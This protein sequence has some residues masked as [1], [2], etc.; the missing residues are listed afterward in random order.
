M[1]VWVTGGSRGL[2]LSAIKIFAQAGHIVYAGLLKTDNPNMLKELQSEYHAYIHI[3]TL[4]VTKEE[5]IEAFTDKISKEQ[6]KLD[7]I[8]NNAGIISGIGIGVTDLSLDELKRSFDIN[9][10]GGILCV[11]HGLPLLI[12]SDNPMIINISSEAGAITQ[13]PSLPY[14]YTLTKSSV[15]MFTRLLHLQYSNMGLCAYAVHP[16]RMMTSMGKPHFTLH[17]D[18]T[19]RGLLAIAQGDVIPDAPYQFIDYTG[20]EMKI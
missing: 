15:N 7:L 20:K 11:K 4:D 9:L 8:I 18:D 13:N 17:P 14:S 19:A 1:I 3:L 2:G 12:K 10:F 6:G 5:Q 16:G